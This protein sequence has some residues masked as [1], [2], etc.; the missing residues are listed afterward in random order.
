MSILSLLD[1]RILVLDGATG[2]MQQQYDLKDTDFHGN[3]FQDHEFPLKGN[4]DVLSLTAPHI[5]EEIHHTYLSAGADIIETNTFSSNR[6]S[7][8]DYGLEGLVHEMNLRSALIARKA[9]DEASTNNKPRFVAGI[10]GPT[11]R[12]A[13]LSPDVEDPSARNI[14]F[15]ELVNTYTEAAVGLVEGNVDFIMIETIFD[16]LNA[17]AAIYALQKTFRKTG[18]NLPI[19]ISGTITD[20]SGRTLS[21]QT[22]SAFLSSIS[23]CNPF[24]VGLNCALGA[25]ALKPYVEELGRTAWMYTS[26]HP[27]AGLPNEFG[28]YDETVEEMTVHIEKFLAEGFVNL[29][30]GCCGTTPDHI[31]EFSRLADSAK[32]RKPKEKPKILNLSGLETLNVDNQSLFVNVGE[33]TNVTGS[34]RFKKMILSGD[35]TSALEVARQQVQSG[36]QIIDINMDEGM[37]DGEVAMETFLNLVMT[38]PDIARVPIMIDSSRWEVIETGLRCVQGKCIVNSISLKDG[39]KAFI[40]KARE[41]L[42]YGAAVIVMA[43][44]ENGQASNLEDRIKIISRS[45]ALLTK[46]VGFP[47]EDIIFDPNVF[48]IATGIEEHSNYGV[49]FIE[50]C[51]WIKNNLPNCHISGGIS[52]VSFSFRGNNVVREAIHTVFLYHAIRAGLTMGIVNAGQLGI[53]ENIPDELRNAVE[54]AVL[55]RIP[56]AT[57]D[58]ISVA[59]KYS[60]HKRVDSSNDDQSWRQLPVNERLSHALVEGLSQFI[61]EDTEELRQKSDNPIQV[62]EGPLMDGMNTVGDLFGSGKMFLPQVV[63][64]ARVMKQAVSH[65]VPFIEAD[66]AAS[67]AAKSKG[68]IVMATVKGDVHDIGKNIVGVVLQCNNYEVFDLGVM[69]P[70]E[71]I[72]NKAKEI[73]ADLIGLSGLITP[74][75]NEMVYV[76]EELEK[77]GFDTP[78]LIGGA[79]TSKAHTAV[80]IAPAYSGSTVYVTDASRSVGVVS[81]ILSKDNREKYLANIRSEY[82]TVRERRTNKGSERPQ[83][84]LEEAR[85]NKLITNW[86]SITIAKPPIG[87]TRLSDYPLSKL[88][89][90]IDWTPFFRT[91]ELAGK[92]PDILSDS[93]VG[94]AASN[95]YA[96]AQ[97]ML[98]QM[99]REKWLTA[100]G[101]IGFWHANSIGD[102]IE[103]WENEQR[104]IPLVTLNHLRQQ[105]ASVDTNLCLA[106]YVAPEPYVDYIGGFAVTVGPEMKEVLERFGDD[107]YNSIMVKALADRLVEAFAEHLHER[108]RKEYWGYSPS[109]SLTGAQLIQEAYRGIRPAPGYPSCP[110]HSEKT[111]LFELLDATQN[112][113]ITLTEN[114]AMFPAASVAG[115][116]FG[117]PAARYFGI[118]KIRDD[119]LTD[120]AHRKATKVDEAAKWLSFSVD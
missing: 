26:V 103:L 116:Y 67:G 32:P 113:G 118:G 59:N 38:E 74:S 114:Y 47:E 21:G 45:Y 7:Q 17:K 91:W 120:Y 75:L 11:T 28:E 77:Q 29:I 100:N 92:F 58:L 6:I 111:K 76:A 35:Y 41:C 66:K 50:A 85:A 8:S 105:N 82:Q 102:D 54:N 12:S 31:R 64:S 73:K 39:E 115:W 86:E 33:R 109:E 93:V 19:M 24:M 78:L 36:A 55:N 44:D 61:I 27:N 15:I 23:H 9:A 16:T 49:D 65:L 81:N 117:H 119:Q 60:A 13:S 53:Y 89:D 72:L 108:V 14:N 51:H 37:L 5:V 56:S 70:S 110:D 106:D 107:D 90:Y 3:R 62:I 83:R 99:V 63:K 84:S 98:E 18:K 97:T 96:D 68:K 112:T 57:E 2:T 101:V 20:A 52:N 104:N 22:C 46:E 40:E 10:L 1:Q 94:E 42:S 88:T 69:V 48:A 4:G 34:S 87:T 43:F 80:K 71:V 25:E 79:T 30:G 95:L